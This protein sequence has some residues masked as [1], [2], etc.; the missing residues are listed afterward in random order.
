MSDRTWPVPGYGNRSV[1]PGFAGTRHEEEFMALAR[2][3]SFENV[4]PDRVARIKESIEAGEHRVVSD[5]AA[6]A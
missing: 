2:L 5:P 4:D 6:R 3:V 1:T